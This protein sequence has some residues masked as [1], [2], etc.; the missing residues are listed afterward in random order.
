[1]LTATDGQLHYLLYFSMH[2][3]LKLVT[4]LTDYVKRKS[5]SF[6]GLDR[7]RGLQEF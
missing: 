6:E 3:Y 1:M 2:L 7:L 4:Y 5:D